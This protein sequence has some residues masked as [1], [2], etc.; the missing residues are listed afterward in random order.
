MSSIAIS[1]CNKPQYHFQDVCCQY[2]CSFYP[3][4]VDAVVLGVIGGVSLFN[5]IVNIETIDGQIKIYSTVV[6]GMF[7]LLFFMR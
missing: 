6:N 4:G 7:L 3:N 1:S 5:I 2:M